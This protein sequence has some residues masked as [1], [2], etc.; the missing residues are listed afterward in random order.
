MISE[1]LWN[2]GDKSWKKVKI[3]AVHLEGT[4]D[5]TKHYKLGVIKKDQ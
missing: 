5:K 2:T 4:L 3:G 1:F